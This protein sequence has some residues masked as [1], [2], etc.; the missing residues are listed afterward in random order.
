MGS[1]RQL[2][3]IWVA[4]TA[5]VT[6]AALVAYRSVVRVPELAGRTA[7]EAILQD[8]ETLFEDPG[9]LGSAVEI[10]VTRAIDDCMRARGFDYR[11]PAAVS[12]LRPDRGRTSGNR[13]ACRE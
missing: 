11:G 9:L 10:S 6:I 3:L 7:P 1:R 12:G 8:P 5:A 2:L 4:T 13:L